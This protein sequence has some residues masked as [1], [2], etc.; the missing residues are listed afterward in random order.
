MCVYYLRGIRINDIPDAGYSD[1]SLIDYD[2]QTL[3]GQIPNSKISIEGLEVIV[4]EIN[5]S[6]GW[7][8]VNPA[9]GSFGIADGVKVKIS[10]INPRPGN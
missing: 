5:N 4:L 7:A 8:R 9:S 1:V 10:S 6:Q 3:T 2:N